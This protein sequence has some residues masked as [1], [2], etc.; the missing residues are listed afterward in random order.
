MRPTNIY[1]ETKAQA[2]LAV[3]DAIADGFPAVIARP[4]LVYGP[5]DLHLLPFFHAVL[6]HRF[7]PIGSRAVWLHPIY[8]D[9]LS[10]ALLRCGQA[11]AA[12]GQCFNLAGREPGEVRHL[13]QVGSEFAVVADRYPPQGARAA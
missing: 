6:R 12:V 2:E 9:D 7:R 1:E 10:D 5:G 11:S 13:G 4:G 3:R 8:I